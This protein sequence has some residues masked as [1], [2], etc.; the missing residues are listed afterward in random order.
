M[1]RIVLSV[2]FALIMFQSFS[3]DTTRP[4]LSKSDYLRKSRSSKT[5]G[6]ILLGT[7]L[8]MAIGSAATFNLSFGPVLGSQSSPSK[9]DNTASTLLGI[10]A[11]AAIVGS[12]IAFSAAKKYKK[13]PA[14]VSLNTERI[15]ALQ[16]YALGSRMQQTVHVRIPF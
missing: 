11:T 9:E 14:T 13:L 3:Q 8:G 10:G 6:W 15:P 12:I 1:K 2:T 4:A 16:Q 7:G 5:T